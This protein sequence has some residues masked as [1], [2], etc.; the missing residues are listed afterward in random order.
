MIEVGSKFDCLEFKG[1][2]GINYI[3]GYRFNNWLFAGVGIGLDLM[4]IKCIT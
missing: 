4:I 3:G 2:T 1:S